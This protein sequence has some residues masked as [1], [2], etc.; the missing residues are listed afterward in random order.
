MEESKN[1]K[2]NKSI[3]LEN[4]EDTIYHDKEYKLNEN[5][6]LKLMLRKNKINDILYNKRQIQNDINETIKEYNFRE[7]DLNIK[8]NKSAFVEALSSSFIGLKNLGNTCYMNSVLQI[9]VHTSQFIEDLF[10]MKIDNTVNKPI[11]KAMILF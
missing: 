7:T 6:E 9:L 11:T 10:T 8:H 2:H 4:K 5:Y 3:F 1:S